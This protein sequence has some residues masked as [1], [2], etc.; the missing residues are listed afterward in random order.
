MWLLHVSEPSIIESRARRRV[1]EAFQ[2]EGKGG[3]WEEDRQGKRE[4]QNQTVRHLFL[5]LAIPSTHPKAL[6]KTPYSAAKLSRQE[7]TLLF[8]TF[9]SVFKF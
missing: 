2:I 1:G 3:R 8:S 6:T 4:T 9:N 7:N 5:F